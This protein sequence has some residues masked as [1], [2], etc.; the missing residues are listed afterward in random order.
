MVSLGELEFWI[1]FMISS[2]LCSILG[3][4][5]CLN[6]FP[7][8]RSQLVEL[9]ESSCRCFFVSDDVSR[10]MGSRP[11]YS[12]LRMLLIPDELQSGYGFRFQLLFIVL[13]QFFRLA[14][15]AHIVSSRLNGCLV[16][17]PAV[18]L[19]TVL[20]YGLN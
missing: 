7:L 14:F 8:A 18:R 9:I 2:V 16:L 4:R 17:L 20:D 11:C 10:S 19:Q 15:D 13:D 12:F 6:V 3:D 1:V 5:A